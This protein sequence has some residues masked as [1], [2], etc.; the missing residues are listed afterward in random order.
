MNLQV[1]IEPLSP[2]RSKTHT[3]ESATKT[4]GVLVFSDFVLN[5]DNNLLQILI[6]IEI[7]VK[8]IASEYSGRCSG[9]MVIVLVPRSRG[10]GLSPSRIIVLCSWARHFTLTVPLS[11][12]KYKWVPANCQRNLAKCWGLPAMD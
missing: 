11:T 8:V 6:K 10:S 7:A 1:K 5:P 12:Q 2:N 9:L 4:T 3:T